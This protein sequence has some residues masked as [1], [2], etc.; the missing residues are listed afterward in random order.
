MFNPFLAQEASTIRPKNFHIDDGVYRSASAIRSSLPAGENFKPGNNQSGTPQ[1]HFM[2][3]LFQTILQVGG[4]L[5]VMGKWVG[6]Q[7]CFLNP[8]T[9]WQT[10]PMYRNF[11]L[12]EVGL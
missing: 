2:T 5:S 3:C 11:P 7:L 12:A 4:W 9:R 6:L 8:L 1:G 10:C